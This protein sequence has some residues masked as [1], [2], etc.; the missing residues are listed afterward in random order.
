MLPSEIATSR[1]S[2]PPRQIYVQ[3]TFVA[4]RIDGAESPFATLPLQAIHPPHP[5]PASRRAQQAQ[6]PAAHGAARLLRD[7]ANRLRQ[8]TTE[9]ECVFMLE[10]ETR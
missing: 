1:P 9:R 10:I 5:L 2:R 7:L 3:S 6:R 4:L 8:A